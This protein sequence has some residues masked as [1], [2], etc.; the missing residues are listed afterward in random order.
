M[1]SPAH[2]LQA[3]ER[4]R[5]SKRQRPFGMEDDR[6]IVPLSEDQQDQQVCH[7]HSRDGLCP[8]LRLQTCLAQHTFWFVIHT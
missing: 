4:I 3:R 5:V 7:A 1:L 2:L 6:I 8:R